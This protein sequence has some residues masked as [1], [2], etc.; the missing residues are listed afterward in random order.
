VAFPHNK[1]MTIGCAGCLWNRYCMWGAITLAAIWLLLAFETPGA[2]AKHGVGTMALSYILIWYVP[3]WF[4]HRHVKSQKKL[5]DRCRTLLILGRQAFEVGDKAGAQKILAR[6]RRLERLWRMGNSIPF[7][8]SLAV[9]AIAWGIVICLLI[10][11]LGIL[12]VN[13]GDTGR[14]LPA[15]VGGEFLIVLCHAQ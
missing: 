2:S 10:R 9:W 5:L 12:V 11:F 14:L 15:N 4:K 6:I 3:I 8:V 7:R 1:P 13:Y